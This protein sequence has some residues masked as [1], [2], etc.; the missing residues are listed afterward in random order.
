MSDRRSKVAQLYLARRTQQQIADELGCGLATVNRDIKA[1]LAEYRAERTEHIDREVAVL[2]SIEAATLE[3]YN[4]E[5]SAEALR[6]RLE[7]LKRRAALL[8]L[9]A[10]AKV[11]ATGKGGGPLEIVFV[12]DWRGEGGEGEE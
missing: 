6:V 2:E 1:I 5:R 3:L 12:N 9:D 11:E 4:R 7:V 8:G 10:P